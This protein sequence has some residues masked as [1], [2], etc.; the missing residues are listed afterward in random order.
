MEAAVMAALWTAMDESL[1]PICNNTA[2]T[3]ASCGCKASGVGSALHCWDEVTDKATSEV[4]GVENTTE[5][6]TFFLLGFTAAPE[7]QGP[8]FALF[9]LTYLT[10]LIGN[11]AMI[12]VILLDPRLH[13]PMYF[14]LSNLSLVDFCYSSTVTPKVLAGLLTDDKLISYNACAAQ[15]FFFVFSAMAE[16]Y[17]LA[18]YD[19]FMAVYKPIH[20]PMITMRS[21]CI[22]LDIGSYLSSF[23][24]AAID[25]GDTLMFCLPFC[26]S[27]VVHDFCDIPPLMILACS[28]KHMNEL[29]LIFIPSFH[30]IFVLGVILI[31]YLLIFITVLNIH[32]RKGMKKA[33]TTCTTHFTAVSLLYG[34]VIIMY[35]NPSSSHSLDKDK[36]SSV[37]YTMVIPMLNPVVY[38]PRN[39][40]I[41]STFIKIVVQANFSVGF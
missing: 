28:D 10:T 35:L 39:K 41:K 24:T 13:T 16:N 31:S 23:L 21:A 37:F 15:M 29:I 36:I 38:S 40:E 7:L 22:H 4:K 25:I 27:K 20:Y 19:Q 3:R 33:L 11:L 1:S 8:L 2:D 34:T 6:S 14:F 26:V 18:S 17:L 9:L 5:V 32:S 30:I 12:L